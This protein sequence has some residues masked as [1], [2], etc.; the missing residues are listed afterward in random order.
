MTIDPSVFAR[1]A[2]HTLLA[3][4]YCEMEWSIPLR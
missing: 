2:E 3:L 4:N 1:S